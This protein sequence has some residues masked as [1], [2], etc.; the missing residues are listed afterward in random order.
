MIVF[1]LLICM[2]TSKSF[3]IQTLDPAYQVAY[4]SVKIEEEISQ[5]NQ[6]FNFGLWSRYNPL[7]SISHVGPV[8]IFATNFSIQLIQSMM[9]QFSCITI[10]QIMRKIKQRN[11]SN[12]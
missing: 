1:I 4:Q 6:C 9:R 12:L 3:K 11:I 8:G 10:V 5:P 2:N 7:S